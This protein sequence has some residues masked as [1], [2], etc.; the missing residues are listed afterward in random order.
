MIPITA[1]RRRLRRRA[2][3]SAD[4]PLWEHT[5]E[6]TCSYRL[7]GGT[8]V[9]VRLM[10]M[11]TDEA[12]ADK[13]DGKAQE[14]AAPVV[15]LKVARG[16]RKGTRKKVGRARAG[17]RE[18]RPTPSFP[19]VS[20]ASVFPFAEAVQ[21][22]GAGQPVRRL[23]LFEKLERSP[24]S[25]VSRDLITNAGKYDLTKGSYKADFVE[26]TELGAAATSPDNQPREQLAA[27][28]KLAIDGVPVFKALY[29][30]NKGSRLPSPEI[31]RDSV[32]EDV[33]EEQR[34]QA[35]DI[36]LENAKYLGLLRTIAG[37]ERVIS[38]EQALEDLRGGAAPASADVAAQSAVQ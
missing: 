5:N 6:S 22:H 20:F 7:S 27:K 25:S 19:P 2:R 12:V 14:N 16:K 33:P 34:T 11:D 3:T 28:F 21:K 31:L 29:D 10:K 1:L 17:K 9:T 4:L 35:V 32:G 30:K 8:S 15:K 26:L 36:F 24:E 23:T 37:A 18:R 13:S 38:I